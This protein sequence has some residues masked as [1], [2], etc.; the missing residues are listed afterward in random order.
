MTD[1]ALVR[2][3]ITQYYY[4]MQADAVGKRAKRDMTHGQW[5][6]KW[7]NPLAV[8]ARNTEAWYRQITGV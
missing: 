6:A 2:G 3:N 7:T 4:Q 8:S 1:K 5:E